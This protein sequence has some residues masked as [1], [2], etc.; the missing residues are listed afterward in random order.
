MEHA[1]QSLNLDSQTL[2]KPAYDSRG[3]SCGRALSFLTVRPHPSSFRWCDP[4]RP[5]IPYLINN[6][7]NIDGIDDINR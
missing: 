6:V 7:K 4:I 3:L 2:R 1:P 5:A